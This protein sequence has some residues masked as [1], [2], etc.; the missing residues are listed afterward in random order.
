VFVA[1][2][3]YLVAIIHAYGHDEITLSRV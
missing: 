1:T 3:I 2:N